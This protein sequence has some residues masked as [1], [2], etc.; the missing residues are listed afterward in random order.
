MLTVQAKKSPNSLRASGEWFLTGSTVLKETIVGKK[1]KILKTR[2]TYDFKGDFEGK[3][4]GENQNIEIDL[5]TG[6][7]K[8]EESEATF[9]GSVFGKR[10]SFRI[11]DKWTVVDGRIPKSP[12]RIIKGTGTGALAKIQGKGSYWGSA[13][14]EKGE[15]TAWIRF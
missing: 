2:S 9:T 6:N 10:G 15:Y 12:F 14:Q 7:S 11:N 13:E 3:W 4:V 8:G 1:K 5:D